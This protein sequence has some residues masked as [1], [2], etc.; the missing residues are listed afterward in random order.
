MKSLLMI[1]AAVALAHTLPGPLLLAQQGWY[2]QTSG[3]TNF[4]Y[5]ANFPEPTTGWV[6]GQAGTILKTTNAGSLWS[7]QVSNTTNF[8]YS[9]FF[10]DA[11]TGWAVGQNGT[12]RKTTNAGGDWLSQTSGTTNFLYSVYFTD[13]IRGSSSEAVDSFSGPRM[14]APTGFRDPVP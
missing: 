14:E 7:A 10:I 9:V 1:L 3:T 4:L 2:N 13:L 5:W 11:N 6:V 12:I 8:L